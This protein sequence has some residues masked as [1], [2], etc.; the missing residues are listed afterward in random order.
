MSNVTELFRVKHMADKHDSYRIAAAIMAKEDEIEL[1]EM[2]VI[3]GFLEG[4]RDANL[5]I[6][7]EPGKGDSYDRGYAAQYELEQV[8]NERTRNK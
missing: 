3:N 5:G 7:H 6:A 4:M 2:S 1:S 8:N